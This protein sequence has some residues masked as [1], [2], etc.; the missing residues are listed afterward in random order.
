MRIKRVLQ[1]T[2]L[3]AL[4]AAAWIGA[5]TVDASAA[6]TDNIKVDTDAQTLQVTNA[7][8][9]EVLFG[10]ATFK[11]T[12]SPKEIKVS[13]WDVYEN[14][15]SNVS[16]DLSKLSN[17]KDNYIAVKTEKD[18]PVYIKIPAAV[19]SQKVSYDAYD[20]TLKIDTVKVGS[21]KDGITGDNIKSG[22][23]YKT[24]YGDWI[25]FNDNSMNVTLGD[26][27]VTQSEIFEDYLY[28]GASLTVRAAASGAAMTVNNA[29]Q[30]TGVKDVVSGKTDCILYEVG[31]F[32]GKEIKLN[33]PKQA[34]APSVKVD[35]K[36][37]TIAL[38]NKVEY[39]FLAQTKEGDLNYELAV[40]S[41]GA[42]TA[43]TADTGKVEPLS[44][45]G[46]F[47]TANITSEGALGILEVRML[48]TKAGDGKHGKGK[49]PSKWAR[50]EI[51]KMGEVKGF[52]AETPLAASKASIANSISL[53]GYKSK[54][55]NIKNES[56]TDYEVKIGEN[57]TPVSLGKGKSAKVSSDPTTDVNKYIYIRTP[58]SAAKGGASPTP[59]KLPGKWT[60]I[61]KLATNYDK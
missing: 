40:V 25:S 45:D 17:V 46:I 30:T 21:S 35:Y 52:N 51:T 4:A 8:A 7:D 18:D 23:E 22:W 1:G 38:K 37:G 31:S 58:G 56:K 13:A 57:G 43:T 32:P 9:K 41:A 61:G 26:K 12:K 33:I 27:G 44:V 42:A 10:I 54:K 16:I 28:Q 20:K 2:A 49:A 3:T 15:N 24:A 60:K 55:L 19:K 59:A 14:K 36:K 53:D 39:R 6:L 50:V 34:N 11:D 5:G 47:E 48:G 29:S